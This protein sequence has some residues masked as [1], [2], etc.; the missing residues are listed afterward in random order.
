MIPSKMNESTDYAAIYDLLMDKKLLEQ[1]F[2]MIASV[3]KK[4]FDK[5]EYING[6]KTL[7]LSRNREFGGNWVNL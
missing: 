2:E 7:K 6:K 3:V 5:T 4:K 1:S